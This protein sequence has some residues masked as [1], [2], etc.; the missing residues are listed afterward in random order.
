LAASGWQSCAIQHRL[1][2]AALRESGL[3]GRLERCDEVRW[4]KPLRPNVDLHLK[5]DDIA[6]STLGETHKFSARFALVGDDKA[7]MQTTA[8][9]TLSDA[10]LPL[11]APSVELTAPDTARAIGTFT[12]A[13]PDVAAF[14]AAYDPLSL[15][16]QVSPWHI[17]GGWMRRMLA[18]RQAEQAAALARGETPPELGPS[19][20]LEN[21]CW[22]GEVRAGETLSYF[23]TVKS[24]RQTSKPGWSLIT[25]H[26]QVFDAQRT[27]VLDFNAKVFAR[28]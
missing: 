3:F 26:N 28:F 9:W 4:L 27:C 25:T 5:I 21:L 20:G 19:P 22:F 17:C 11:G 6:L 7:L 15:Y 16:N 14:N 12:F 18:H 24:V 23:E 10:P 8:H 2:G 13:L 1:F